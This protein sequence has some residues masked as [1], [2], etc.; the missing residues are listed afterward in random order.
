MGRPPKLSG[1][2]VSISVHG[3]GAAWCDGVFAGDPE[4]L[5]SARQAIRLNLPVTVGDQTFPA[6]GDNAL[7]ALAALMSHSQQSVI[8]DL[9]RH[10]TALLETNTETPPAEVWGEVETNV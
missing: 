10:L 9:P 6:N 7:G 5:T 2:L 1:D 4:I 3:K 8:V